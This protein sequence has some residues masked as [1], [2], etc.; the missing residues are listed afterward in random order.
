MGDPTWL[1]LFKADF[2]KKDEVR[3]NLR[4]KIRIRDI[5]ELVIDKMEPKRLNMDIKME[6]GT[7][8]HTSL[9]F[10]TPQKAIQSRDFLMF[11][12]KE[13]GS[14]ESERV[15]EWLQQAHLR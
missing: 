10:D 13:V 2:T 14:R 5:E 4:V 9:Y 1:C 6:D 3:G 7:I 11:N 12:K 15:V 8:A